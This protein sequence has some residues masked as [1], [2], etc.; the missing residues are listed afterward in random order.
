ME[1]EKSDLAGWSAGSQLS[2]GS[3]GRARFRPLLCAAVQACVRDVLLLLITF[4][5]M[6][7]SAL[8]PVRPA[9]PMVTVISIRCQGC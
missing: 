8:S 7:F 3:D 5:I 2:C 9:G 1:C 6:D 4:R